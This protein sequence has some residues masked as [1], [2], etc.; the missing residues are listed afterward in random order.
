[1]HHVPGAKHKFFIPAKQ[2]QTVKP[3]IK[4]N[5]YFGFNYGC[6]SAINTRKTRLEFAGITTFPEVSFT[7]VDP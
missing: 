4:Q 6:T 7:A 1:M 2:A 5:S 3:T